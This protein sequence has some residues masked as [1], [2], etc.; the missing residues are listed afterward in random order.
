MSNKNCPKKLCSYYYGN[1]PFNHD[2]ILE[3]R[4][5][6]C[7]NSIVKSLIKNQTL[8]NCKRYCKINTSNCTK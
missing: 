1:C 8:T 3:L 5:F 7:L 2:Y 4:L 6:D